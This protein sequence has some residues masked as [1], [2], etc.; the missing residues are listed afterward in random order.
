M[1]SVKILIVED[2]PL[3]ADDISYY[4]SLAGY[5]NNLIAHN[6]SEAVSLL[7]NNEIDFVFLD[8]NLESSKSGVDLAKEINLNYLIPFAFITSHADKQSIQQ[9]KVL[10]PVGY[11]VKPF[12]GKDI[13]AVLALGLEL[14][15]TYMDNK[16]EFDFQ[17]LN[18]FTRTELT[19]QEKNTILKL[20][21]GKSNKQISDELFVSLNTTKTHLKNIFLKLEVSSRTE[22]MSILSK[23]K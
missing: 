20:I 15:Y 18:R 10:H 11:I 2:E 16:S 7:E 3:I 23:C 14:F 22:A 4:L 21:E 17:K 5:S 9:I 8:Q 13:P 1:S 6:Y 12:N 19:T